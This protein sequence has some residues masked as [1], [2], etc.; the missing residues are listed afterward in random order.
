[1]ISKKLKWD[2]INWFQI[3]KKIL[4]QQRHIYTESKKGHWNQMHLLQ[5][6]LL[7]SFDAKLMA[8]CQATENANGEND[9]IY[10]SHTQKIALASNLTLNQRPGLANQPIK[11]IEKQAKHF[12]IKLAL[13]PQ[14]EALFEKTSSCLENSHYEL[15]QRLFSILDGKKPQKVFL[16]EFSNISEIDHLKLL[17][18]LATCQKIKTQLQ[19]WLNEGI[20]TEWENTPDLLWQF[21]QRKSPYFLSNLLVNIAFTGLEKFLKDWYFLNSNSTNKTASCPTVV[22]YKTAFVITTSNPALFDAMIYQVEIWFKKEIG[23][24]PSKKHVVLSSHGFDFLGFQFISVRQKNGIF[25]MKMRPSK[26][27]KQRFIKFSRQLIQKNKSAS[28]YTLIR[29][30]SRLILGWANYFYFSECKNDFAQLDFVLFQQIRAWVF[31]RKSKGLNS[32]TK[33]KKKYFPEKRSYFFQGKWYQNNW[34]LNGYT[35][36]NSQ[37]KTIFLPKMV[38]V[39]VTVNGQ[40]RKQF[41]TKKMFLKR[42]P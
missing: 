27:S 8:V 34:I 39:S 24:F 31:R 14:W 35:N 13:E 9:F 20:L 11:K 22:R 25:R 21:M 19:I 30:L 16:L 32:R 3:Q 42:K 28:S 12:L 18:K 4:N 10:L 2:N 40:K 26:E 38:W 7:Q 37:F 33:L 23:L 17:T 5:L 1:M 29:L 41:L 36:Q 15:T 6:S